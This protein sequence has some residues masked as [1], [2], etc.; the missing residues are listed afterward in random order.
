MGREASHMTTAK[1]KNV[2]GAPLDE[3]VVRFH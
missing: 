3:K 2:G 1:S